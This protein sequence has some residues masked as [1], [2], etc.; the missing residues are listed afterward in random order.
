MLPRYKCL[1]PFSFIFP[2]HVSLIFA[3]FFPRSI[4]PVSWAFVWLEFRLCQAI[5]FR[6]GRAV[7]LE[8]SMKIGGK[9]AFC[10]SLCCNNKSKKNLNS[11][12]WTRK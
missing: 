3:E 5:N 2:A 9:H 10:M 12:N 8:S 4:L 7:M 6:T 11:G 1:I